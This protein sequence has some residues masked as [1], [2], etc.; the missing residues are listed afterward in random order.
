MDKTKT[1]K[2]PKASSKKSLK[3]FKP[4]TAILLNKKLVA[5]TLV[6]CLLRNDIDTFQDVLVS[7]LRALSKTDLA[8]KTGLGRRTLYDLIEGKKFDPR[9]STLSAILSK[10]AG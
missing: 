1:S 4:D 10:I 8:Q 5:E 7:H 2:K 9:L 3:H 6:E